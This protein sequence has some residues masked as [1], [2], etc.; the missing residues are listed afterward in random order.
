MTRVLRAQPGAAA[1]G[2]DLAWRAGSGG[3]IAH[4]RQRALARDAPSPAVVPSGPQSPAAAPQAEAQP[5]F[6]VAVEDGLVAVGH[7]LQTVAAPE[8][9]Y[10]RGLYNEGARQI[11]LRKVALQAEVDAGRMTEKAMAQ[12]LSDMRHE[13]AIRVRNTG[14]ALYKK[15]AEVFDAIRGNAERP[16]YQALRDAGKSDAEIIA[17]A[18]KTNEFI[19]ALPRGVRWAGRALW[20]VQAGI[21]VGIVLSA[22]ADQRAAVAQAEAEGI[23]GGAAGAS[24]GEGLCIVFAIATEGWGLIV[25]GLIGGIAGAEASRGRL[26]DFLDIAPHAAPE[27]SGR[28]FVVSGCWD[29]SDF[30]IFSVCGKTLKPEDHVLVVGTGRISGSMVGGHGHY[31]QIE[32]TP[33]SGAASSLFGGNDARWVNEYLLTPATAADL[34][35]AT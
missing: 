13:L 17:S 27:L 15:G 29:E 23:I 16:T 21:S 35:A 3:H 5:G 11:A 32:V 6:V 10:L 12:T 4:H 25:C 26:F 2:L 28:F 19:N 9:E 24:A 1:S 20:V 31:R 34:A 14:S 22:P 7:V 33:A 18:A 30:L 8:S